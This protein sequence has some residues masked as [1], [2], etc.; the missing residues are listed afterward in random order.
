MDIES[1]YKLLERCSGM[2]LIGVAKDPGEDFLR[3]N[4]PGER[5]QIWLWHF[6]RGQDIYFAGGVQG[7]DD[8]KGMGGYVHVRADL[9][10]LA[11]NRHKKG[12]LPKSDLAWIKDDELQVNF[13]KSFLLHRLPNP[14]SVIHHSLGGPRHIT[15]LID[16]ANADLSVMS[17]VIREARTAWN[18]HAQTYRIF[19]WFKEV[20]AAAKREFLWG[21]LNQKRP[22]FLY[23]R[24]LFMAHQDI[25]RLFDSL[26]M[27]IAEKREI[28]RTVKQAWSQRLYRQNLEGKKQ[29]N[30]ILS[31]EANRLLNELAT[32]YKMS[33]PKTIEYLIKE[34]SMKGGAS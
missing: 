29:Y 18:N 30:F 21:W 12:F 16:C 14:I 13:L 5:V 34:A 20:D 33:R 11:L 6:L 10:Q 28:V 27:H 19:D 15:A 24:D 3:A 1:I 9:C 17:W 32:T 22:Q 8:K 2:A 7:P 31:D 26:N 4:F 25:L 23:G